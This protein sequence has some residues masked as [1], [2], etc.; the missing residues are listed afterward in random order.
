V[1]GWY[2]LGKGGRG[3]GN[4]YDVARVLRDDR[5]LTITSEELNLWAW[6]IGLFN[7][8]LATYE[9]PMGCTIRVPIYMKLATNVA[10]PGCTIARFHEALVCGRKYGVCPWLLVAVGCHENPWSDGI[11]WGVEDWRDRI[12]PQFGTLL[13]TQAAHSAIKLRG[14]YRAVGGNADHPTFEQTVA[15][16]GLYTGTGS[17]TWGPTVWTIRNRAR[18]LPDNAGR[19]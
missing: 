6:Q 16:G 3:G 5:G 9:W 18:H 13:R 10:A 8:H 19:R 7:H 11:A 17:T 15:V 4:A 14:H 12:D 2:T 1:F